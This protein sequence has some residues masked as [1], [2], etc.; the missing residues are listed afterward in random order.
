MKILSLVL[1]FNTAAIADT[2]YPNEVSDIH[3]FGIKHPNAPEQLSQFE[4]LIGLSDCSSQRQGQDGKWAEPTP[5]TWRFKYIMDGMA[6]QDET[7]K[8]DGNHSGSI[9]QFNPEQQK[10]HVH[11][12]ASSTPSPSLS[13]WTGVKQEDGNIVLYKPQLA[14]NGMAGFSRLTFYDITN[15][16]Y[17]W[18]GEWVDESEKVTFPF[19][20]IDCQ[21][22]VT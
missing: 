1:L 15:T 9:R 6:I 21:K 12:Y 10:W 4:P 7:L 2:Q 11:Y 19:W 14:P 22:R 17:K 20:K 16:S 8:A 3:P 5:M 13:S 18:I